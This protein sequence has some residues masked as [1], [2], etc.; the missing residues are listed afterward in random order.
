MNRMRAAALVVFAAMLTVRPADAQT[1]DEAREPWSFYA[2]AYTY[3]VPEDEDYIQPTMT[4]DRGWM[5]FEARFNYEDR[6]TGSVWAGYN[7][8][9]GDDIALEI[10]PML[11]VVFGNTTGIAPGYKGSIGWRRLELYSESEYVFDADDSADSFFYTWSELTVSPVEWWRAG[12]VI[13]RTK[14]YETEFD[15]QRGLLAGFSYKR[16][17]VTGHLFNPDEGTMFVLAVGVGF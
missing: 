10:A 15:I 6:D 3:F 17:D 4:A 7:I 2:S 16:L 8:A 1:E 5:H 14:V 11:G 9:V 12:L 13:Q